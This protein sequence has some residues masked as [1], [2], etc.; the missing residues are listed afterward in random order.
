[1][2]LSILF[3]DDFLLA[4][5][6]PPAIHS[7]MVSSS[8]EPS[9]AQ[10]LLEQH[11]E[12][13]N[14]SAKRED[15]GL[16]QRLDY[17]TSGVLLVAKTRPVWDALHEALLAGEIKKSYLCVCEGRF[18]ERQQLTT[19]IGSPYRRAGK[20]RVYVAAPKKPVRALQGSSVFT[21]LAYDEA[22]DLSLIEVQASPARRHQVRA[23]AAHLGHVLV[24]DQLYGSMREAPQ[25]PR[26][27]PAFILHS[28]EIAFTHPASRQPIRVVANA[29]E[30]LALLFPKNTALNH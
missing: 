28:H 22:S 4:L 12:L 25:S 19:Y 13:A 18:P 30:Y 10:L 27:P 26:S 1:M 2:A 9:I 6:K 7:A 8:H 14:A 15:A 11:P 23:H 24:G 3:E 5:D 16:V 17:E 29:P 21:A 20:V